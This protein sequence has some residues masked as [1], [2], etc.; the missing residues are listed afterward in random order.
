MLV[1]EEL[2]KL[3]MS[4]NIFYF[5]EFYLLS[6]I[7]E[8]FELGLT[9]KILVLIETLLFYIVFYTLES[10]FLAQIAN[11]SASKN[12]FSFDLLFKIVIIILTL[13]RE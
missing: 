3:F 10:L 11:V 5:K 1:H 4:P 13:L 8:L 6:L 12:F 2:L 9:D 7:V